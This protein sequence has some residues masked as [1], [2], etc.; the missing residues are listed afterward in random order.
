M[1]EIG[2][3]GAVRAPW[4]GVR[5][6]GM[7]KQLRNGLILAI[8]PIGVSVQ[9]AKDDKWRAVRGQATAL[10][11][12]IDQ[13]VSITQI[14]RPQPNFVMISASVALLWTV[15]NRGRRVAEQQVQGAEG[16]DI[17]HGINMVL[18]AE[19]KDL[20]HR[21]RK[22]VAFAGFS[23]LIGQARAG[24]VPPQKM[25][26]RSGGRDRKAREQRKAVLTGELTE[27][28]RILRRWFPSLPQNI[29]P[30]WNAGIAGKGLC[31]KG[32]LI[33]Q[34]QTQPPG[35]GIGGFSGG[36]KVQL[37]D[38]HHV[39]IGLGE[40]SNDVPYLLVRSV[41]DPRD[42]RSRL[43]A[44]QRHVK[45]R[46]PQMLRAVGNGPVGRMKGVSQSRFL[47]TG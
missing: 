18:G 22:E 2:G 35:E 14:V 42:Y 30:R 19:P 29:Q 5:D 6:A 13:I 28:K 8:A 31:G 40:G 23:L 46:N 24:H 27:A 45:G 11:G 47:R 21:R 12:V 4:F 43:F 15:K 25:L 10:A 39:W 1:A 3:S 26:K 33:G 34:S 7:V 9:V 32:R 38:Q 20:Q 41:V 36:I 37:V 16:W 44:K 17:D